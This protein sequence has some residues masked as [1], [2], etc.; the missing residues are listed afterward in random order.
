MA[1]D[2]QVTNAP[3]VPDQ[4]IRG[5]KHTDRSITENIQ[6][7]VLTTVTPKKWFIGFT[8]SFIL[9]L[10]L[11]LSI[12][13]VII[14]G[15]GVWGLNMPVAWG[16]AIINF[17]WWVGIGH[18]GTLISAILFLLKQDWRTSIS[19]YAESMTLFAVMCAG[20]FPLLHMGRVW[21]FFWMFP[22]PSTTGLWPQF[23]SPLLWDVF[24]IS[25]YALVSL[26][27]WYVGLVPD[28]A[29]MRDQ[30]GHK[31]L[32][33]VYGIF[34]LGWRG[35]ARHWHRYQIAYLLLAGL[36]TP[37]VVSVHTVVSFDFAIAII[38]GWHTTIF[39]P[40]FVSGAVFSGFAMVLTLL[41]PMR[42]LY[43]LENF[44]TE[45]HL[46]VMAKVMLATGLIVFYGYIVEAFT[47]WYSA[48][49]YEGFM[50][51]NRMS[52]PY[53]PYYW[54]LIFCNGIVP[55]ALWFPK[56][57]KNPLILFCIA[58][59]VNIGMWLERFIIVVTSLHRDFLPSAWGMYSP[60]EWDWMTYAGTIGLFLTFMYLFMR[61][62][63]MISGFE[64]RELWHKTKHKH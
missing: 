58:I 33:R 15:V 12:A 31:W 36:A 25:T 55:I 44:I 21:K 18:A 30:A 13:W 14:K 59:T 5:E 7:I 43:K 24:A 4:W 28:L 61:V 2:I 39:P 23:R 32:K 37:L 6:G 17:V 49:Q 26:M 34:S 40:Y 41:I 9:F 47:A 3:A 20:L 63:P 51:L 42:K 56:V 46:D 10:V 64:M 11:Q 19:R 1:N 27:F 22:Y 48:N 16:F 52:G 29:S 54:L 62:I 57:R 60:T 53:A 38:P 35:A 50:L 8:I 45:R